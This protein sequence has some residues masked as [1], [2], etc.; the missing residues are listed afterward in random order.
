MPDNQSGIRRKQAGDPFERIGKRTQEVIV[1]SAECGA[2][3][4]SNLMIV[5]FSHACP[6]FSFSRPA[7]RADAILVGLSGTG[8]VRVGQVW[9]L[10]EPGHVYY[11]PAGVPHAY[12]SGGSGSWNLVWAHFDRP[13]LGGDIRVEKTDAD[14]ATYR[15]VV[16]HLHREVRGSGDQTTMHYWAE[17][18]AI[19]IGR[20]L[21]FRRRTEDDRL[22]RL[23]EQVEADLTRRWQGSDFSA[24]T[25]LSEERVRQLSQHQ[26]GNSPMRYTAALRMKRACYLLLSTCWTLEAV[27]DSVGYENAFAFST[28]FKRIVGRSP[29]AF[30]A[31]HNQPGSM[32][33]QVNRARINEM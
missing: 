20:I 9:N 4:R 10:L 23:W 17:L 2:L 12:H 14:L 31:A 13:F 19:Y 8:L 3:G 30:R 15:D 6:E 32:P 11:M 27:S 18:I 26:F 29:Q 1:T 28:A 7:P 33:N 25:G 5:G 16:R 22:T 24:I 21:D